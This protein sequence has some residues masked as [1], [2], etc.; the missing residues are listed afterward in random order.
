MNTK[1]FFTILLSAIFV[2]ANACSNFETIQ[3]NDK[4]T[5]E[6]RNLKDFHSIIASTGMHVVVSTG[7][8]EKIE[9]KADENLL[10]YIKTE[11]KEGVLKISSSK[12]L[13]SKNKIEVYVTAKLLKR[14]AASSGAD[15]KSLNTIVFEKMELKTS[16]GSSITMKVDCKQLKISTSSGSSIL[17][18]GKTTQLQAESSSGSEIKAFD[19]FAEI[20]EVKVSSGSDIKINVSAELI[21]D[22]SSGGG[23]TYIGKPSVVNKNTSSGGSVNN[24]Q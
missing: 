23:I 8:E 10:Q 6:I 18:S 7:E 20:C 2:I 1:L 16:S 3:G 17:V 5:N 12:S 24:V 4:Y 11:V 19:L 22:A 9:I 15:I 14:A 13:K 21:A